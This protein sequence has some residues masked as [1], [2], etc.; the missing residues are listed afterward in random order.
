MPAAARKTRWI[1]GAT[2]I[3]DT[4]QCQPP[5][6][7]ERLLPYKDSLDDPEAQASPYS[8]YRMRHHSQQK[9]GGYVGRHLCHSSTHC[10]P[11]REYHERDSPPCWDSD[12]GN[13]TSRLWESD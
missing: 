7:L 3:G 5:C 12:G 8:A 6:A 4:C 1:L 9:P 11:E 10:I 13:R 2:K